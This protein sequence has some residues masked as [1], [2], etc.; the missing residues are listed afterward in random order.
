MS[1]HGNFIKKSVVNY[2]IICRF[3]DLKCA[4]FEK[5]EAFHACCL[6]FIFRQVCDFKSKGVKRRNAV[7]Y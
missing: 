3:R 4:E 5:L 6:Y 7:I 1:L 2:M